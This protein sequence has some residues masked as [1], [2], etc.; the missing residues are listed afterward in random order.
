MSRTCSYSGLYLKIQ[1]Q[2]GLGKRSDL[3]VSH[4][5]MCRMDS[6]ALE[7]GFAFKRG[8]EH[9]ICIGG[10]QTFGGDLDIDKT[11][12]LTCK[13]LQTFL[14]AGF[15]SDFFVSGQGI[16]KLPENDVLCHSGVSPVS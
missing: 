13:T 9:N 5:D 15:D 4:R 12:N 11:G 1:T 6:V 3:T 8:I 7:C 10:G 14:D 2:S 16:G